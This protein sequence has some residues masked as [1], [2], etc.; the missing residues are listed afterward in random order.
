MFTTKFQTLVKEYNKRFPKLSVDVDQE[1]ARYREY[2]EIVRPMVIDT[3]AYLHHIFETNED[4]TIL[5]EGANAALLDID[6]GMY[7]Q[8]YVGRK[9]LFNSGVSVV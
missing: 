5:V 3:I 4:K 7:L 8:R 2:A 1:L 9:F 6:F